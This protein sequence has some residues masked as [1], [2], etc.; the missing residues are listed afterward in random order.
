MTQTTQKS[1]KSINENKLIQIA[2][3]RSDKAAVMTY[4]T[5]TE[6]PDLSKYP[7]SKYNRAYLTGKRGYTILDVDPKKPTKDEKDGLL[8]SEKLMKGLDFKTRIVRSPS[9]GLHYYFKYD[10]EIPHDTGFNGYSIDVRNNGGYIVAPP[11]YDD[12]GSY[13]IEE[14][15]EICEMP[16]QIKQWLLMHRAHITPEKLNKQDNTVNPNSTPGYASSPIDTVFTFLKKDIISFLYKLPTE[17]VNN[18]N[19][20]LTITSAMKSSKTP[21]FIIWNKWSKQ[22]ANYDETKNAHTWNTIEPKADMS[23]FLAIAKQEHMKVKIKV[24]RFKTLDIFTKTANLVVN[25]SFL[26]SLKKD[27]IIRRPM[28]NFDFKKHRTLL[29]KSS[30][31]TGK[32]TAIV[33]L[34][35]RINVGKGYKI[36]SVVSRKTLASQHET[37]FKENGINMKNYEGLDPRKLNSSQ[38]LAIQID[39]LIKL[40]TESWHDTIIFLDEINSMIDYVATSETM[41]SRRNICF[42]KLAIIL[43]QASYIVACDADLSD[44]VINYF[45]DLQIKTYLIH[46]TYQ[47]CT[48]IK[49]YQYDSRDHIFSV[50]A[51]KLKK[52]IKFV[53]CFDS[54]EEMN[55]MIKELQK[56]YPERVPDYKIYSAKAGA[57]SDFL[58]VK[59]EWV[60]KFVFYSP[61]VI[62]GVDYNNLEKLDVFMIANCRSVNPLQFSQMVARTRNIKTLHF[63]IKGG[64]A[65]IRYETQDDMIQEYTG[66]LKDYNKMIDAMDN[67]EGAPPQDVIECLKSMESLTMNKLTGEF[68]LENKIFNRMFYSCEYNNHIMKSNMLFHF[69]EILKAKGFNIQLAK[70]KVKMIERE[71]IKVVKAE[72]KEDNDQEIEIIVTHEMENLTECQQILKQQMQKRAKIL[73]IEIEN[74]EHRDELANNYCF[75]DHLNISQLVNTNLNGKFIEQK[76][77]EFGV[78]NVKSNTLKVKLIHD[79]ATKLNIHCLDVDIDQFKDRLSEDVKM[80]QSTVKLIRSVF[81]QDVQIEDTFKAWF[82]QMVKMVRHV[83]PAGLISTKQ[84]RTKGDSKSKFI[85]Q[86]TLKVDILT[87][88]LELLRLRNPLMKNINPKIMELV[89]VQAIKPVKMF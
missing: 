70:L 41:R 11:S 3:R 66:L 50:L 34:I 63:H 72:V 81:R 52:N 65:A 58:N 31:G 29:I 61:K 21:L 13:V 69:S 46:N 40:D 39:S 56:L 2:V 60:D 27:N 43:R 24:E 78:Q 44:M 82:S 89:D 14:D 55:V 16:L 67:T 30:T 5:I 19:K 86:H 32:T 8:K 1:I 18:R 83:A 62:Y 51:Q 53:A 36:L 42:N 75:S 15:N 6:T 59:E 87:R 23:H 71:K 47:N 10:P 4:K 37:N 9:G 45:D 17:Y 64:S 33:E 85:Q 74:V 26:S 49:A 28:D 25:S 88:H 68:E 48:G 38:Y 77:K 57:N 80:K 73:N 12:R 35:K 54:V 20:W 84:V 7:L 22:S 79:I 76:Y